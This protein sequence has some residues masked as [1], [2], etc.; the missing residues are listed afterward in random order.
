MGEHHRVDAGEGGDFVRGILGR[1][2]QREAHREVGFF[3]IRTESG[4]G[5]ILFDCRLAE[6]QRRLDELQFQAVGA[7]R[8]GSVP[9][10]PK[11]GGLNAD[12]LIGSGPR[13]G[14]KR[15]YG[16]HCRKD[17]DPSGTG[18]H[19]AQAHQRYLGQIHLTHFKHFCYI[20]NAKLFENIAKEFAG[21]QKSAK[22]RSF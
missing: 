1:N 18:N 8:G 11:P 3:G 15:K 16:G 13:G 10:Q 7:I 21:T 17:N 14:N 20:E 19:G 2:R 22:V 9:A 6:G 4:R 12:D 5:S